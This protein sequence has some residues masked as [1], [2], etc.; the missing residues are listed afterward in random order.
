MSAFDACK[1]A[2]RKASSTGCKDTTLHS[3]CRMFYHVWCE[4]S[5]TYHPGRRLQY[6]WAKTD[7]FI[8]SNSLLRFL[9]VLLKNT[10]VTLTR[11]NTYLQSPNISWADSNILLKTLPSFSL[12]QFKQRYTLLKYFQLHEETQMGT[13]QHSSTAITMMD[14]DTRLKFYVST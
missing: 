6:S 8:S 5:A 13:Q 1:D 14:H 4:A 12:E 3:L 11:E 7:V 10:T 2:K 9:S